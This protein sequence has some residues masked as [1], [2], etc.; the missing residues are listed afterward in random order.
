MKKFVYKDRAA[1]KRMYSFYDKAM[2]SLGIEYR[3]EYIDTSF[4][5]TH[6][7][8]AGDESK[9]KLFTV[10]GGNGCT[11][12]N[13]QLFL[14]L[15]KD[16][17]IIAP[18]VIGMP[19]KSAPY[20]LLNT[21]SRDFGKWLNELLGLMGIKKIPFVVSSYSSA[22]LLSLAEVAPSRIEK[23]ALVVPSGFAHGPLIPIMRTMF[24]PMLR[25]Y[26]APSEKSLDGILSVMS[27]RNDALMREF[28]DLMMSS[29]K[30]EMRPP[31]EFSRLELRD[32]RAPVIVFASD[33]D[34]FF[35]ADRVFPRARRLLRLRPVCCRIR[36]RHLPS[37]KTMRYVC[38]KIH[39]FFS[40]T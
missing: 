3:E 21:Y 38:M 27:S 5:T 24:I 25:Y 40:D 16:Y 28:F 10:H 36:C 18:D 19:G 8:I 15:L 2:A 26:F 7:I 32:F 17:C 9:P 39:D 11:P 35:P 22:M 30:M 23:A 4:G 20:R 12:I 6:V 31:R 1:M 33:E 29:Y 14:P 37:S 13:L 34:V